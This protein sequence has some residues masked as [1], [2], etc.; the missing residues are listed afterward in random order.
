MN[1]TATTGTDTRRAT[2]RRYAIGVAF[3]FLPS[4]ALLVMLPLMVQMGGPSPLWGTHGNT[5]VILSPWVAPAIGWTAALLAVASAVV[6]ARHVVWKVLLGLAI[7]LVDGC[8]TVTGA[9]V[10]GMGFS[11]CSSVRGVDGQTYTFLD[12]SFMQGQAMNLGVLRRSLLLASVYEDLGGTNG[13]SPRSWTSL[14]RQQES[15]DDYGQLRQTPGGTIL[16]IRY[17]NHAFFA[18]SPRGHVFLG[19]D[20]IERISPF[21]LLGP[22][23]IPSGADVDRLMKIVGS[24]AWH[25]P[26]VPGCPMVEHFVVA[27]SNPNPWVRDIARRALEQIGPRPDATDD[28]G[29]GG[30]SSSG[31]SQDEGPILDLDA[32]MVS[33]DARP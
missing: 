31:S 7:L 4:Q 27:K 26:R 23:A 5:L 14:V 2:Y 6:L 20:T 32:W 3:A 15:S 24:C 10:Q 11:T 21:A 8:A 33:G 12:L 29:A 1:D 13:D 17:D 19:R 25:Q 16:G 30:Q 9:V 18:Y 22:D 28:R